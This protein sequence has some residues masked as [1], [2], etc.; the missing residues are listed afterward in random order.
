MLGVGVGVGVG[1]VLLV[2]VFLL[3]DDVLLVV[4][5]VLLF[6]WMCA[7]M[8]TSRHFLLAFQVGSVVL[9]PPG[10]ICKMAF[11]NSAT[12]ERRGNSDVHNPACRVVQVQFRYLLRRNRGGRCRY[13][14]RRADGTV[15]LKFQHEASTA[16]S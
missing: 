4:V 9:G 15:C 10:S 16:K 1:V 5:V 7:D 11:D 2:I 6:R 13:V 8:M 12:V 14:P 3:V